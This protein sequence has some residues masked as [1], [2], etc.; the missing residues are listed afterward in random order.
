MIPL[1]IDTT[2]R[3]FGLDANWPLLASFEAQ[4]FEG[5][6][7]TADTPGL[8]AYLEFMRTLA[9]EGYT[10]VNQTIGYFRP[11]AADDN[12][13]FTIDGPYLQGVVTSTAGISQEEFGDTWGVTAPPAA[14]EGESFTVPTDHQLSILSGSE[15]PD[16]AWELMEFLATNEHAVTEYTLPVESSLPP[17][18]EPEGAIADALE[19]P[20]YQSI[21]EEVIPAVIRPP[22]GANY[23]AASSPVMASVQTAMTSDTP[24]DQIVADLQGQL[25]TVLN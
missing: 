2:N 3:P 8:R 1:G 23:A 18:A 5:S 11:I 21:Q 10:E 16:A 25:E 6:E 7:A 17:L 22:W 15:N 14:P 13:A 12:V 9:T 4:P 20:V 19:T 24:I